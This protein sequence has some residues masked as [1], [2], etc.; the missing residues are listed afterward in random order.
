[1]YFPRGKG[2]Q[3]CTLFVHPSPF[4][5]I[6]IVSKKSLLCFFYFLI[7]F[8][9]ISA[10]SKRRSSE[11][12]YKIGIL[13]TF[14]KTHRKIPSPEYLFLIKLHPWDLRIYKKETP[15]HVFLYTFVKNTYILENLRTAASERNIKSINT[16][17]SLSKICF[18]F[19]QKKLFLVTS[20]ICIKKLWGHAN[21]RLVYKTRWI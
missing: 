3:N 1:M 18:F 15:T 13:K 7:L 2:N 14:V 21:F 4:L 5:N 11:V 12:F 10:S 17:R 9:I 8:W 20:N 6:F 19:S 16:A